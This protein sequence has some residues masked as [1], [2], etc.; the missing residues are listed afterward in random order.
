MLHEFIAANR[1]EIIVR[2]RARISSRPAPRPTDVE[3]EHGVPLFLDQLAETLRL[4]LLTHVSPH[5]KG[6]TLIPNPKISETAAKHGKELLQRGFT[7]AQVVNDYGGVCQTITELAVEKAAPITTGEFKTLNFCLDIATAGAVTEY[8]RLRAHEGTERLGLLAHE[9][10]NH[11]NSAVLAFE[12]LKTGS[13]GVGGSTGAVL[14]RGLTGLR[15]LIDREL[16]EARLGANIL[17][18]STVIVRD[19]I[20][21]VEIAATLDANARGIQFS[22]AS[23]EKHV[24]VYADRQIL[25]SVVAN[26]LQNAF[27][28]THDKGHVLLR[29]QATNDR[30]LIDVEDQCGGLPPG[31]A[32]EL[33]RPFEQRGTNRTGLGLGLGICLRGVQVNDGEIHVRNQPGTGCVFTVDLPRQVAT[34]LG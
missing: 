25:M 1:A 26:L 23:V 15:D 3:L 27:K 12:V 2:C 8:G 33:F 5:L 7:I 34:S 10:R 4:A 22:V 31:Q 6:L 19:F 20:E 9:L 13:V 17:Q 14:A 30:V 21:D 18:R 32:E 11:L 24:T 28:F 16:A 29:A